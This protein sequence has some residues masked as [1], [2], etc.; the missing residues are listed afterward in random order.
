MFY[1]TSTSR[2]IL[3]IRQARTTEFRESHDSQIDTELDILEEIQAELDYVMNVPSDKR[4]SK[5]PM[6][7]LRIVKLCIGKDELL[8]K[9]FYKLRV[10]NYLT[11]SMAVSTLKR[12]HVTTRW[13]SKAH[14]G[15]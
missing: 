8:S 6:H 15:F 4:L 10:K 9:V 5:H 7:A 14:K 2:L 3:R 11:L 13:Y 1:A 12:Q